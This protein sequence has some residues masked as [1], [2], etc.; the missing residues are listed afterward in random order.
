MLDA[1]HDENGGLIG[2][3][4]I[5]R[6]ITERRDAQEALRRAAE[7]LAQ[8]QK[9]EALS[10]LTR[11]DG[12]HDVNNMLTVSGNTQ[13]L[14]APP[15][16]ALRRDGRDGDIAGRRPDPT[17]RRLPVSTVEPVG[18]SISEHLAAFRIALESLAREHCAANRASEELLRAD[19]CRRAGAE[20]QRQHRHQRARTPAGGTITITGRNV[21]LVEAGRSYLAISSRSHCG[22]PVSVSIPQRS[23]R[24]SS[25]SS[26]P[27]APRID[28]PGLPCGSMGLLANRR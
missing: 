13:M 19:Q 23:R 10:Q 4:K 26:P 9:L 3:G 28:R 16:L 6:D 2:F 18:I 12:A 11:G 8:S 15:D 21:H 7:R 22:T 20:L 24:S 17:T 27:R 25:L 14:E 1:I 5:T